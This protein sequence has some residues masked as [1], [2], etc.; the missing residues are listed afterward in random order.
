MKGLT[1]FARLVR[2]ARSLGLSREDRED[3][4]E[5]EEE[6]GREDVEGRAL[7]FTPFGAVKLVEARA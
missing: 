7:S 4:G 1:R 6:G 5:G 3:E 2:S